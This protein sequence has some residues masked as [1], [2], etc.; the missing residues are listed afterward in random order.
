MELKIE[1]HEIDGKKYLSLTQLCGL[2]DY[3]IDSVKCDLAKF[4]FF[5]TNKSKKGSY[6][7]ELENCLK[8]IDFYMKNKNHNPNKRQIFNK[9][10]DHLEDS[11][12]ENLPSSKAINISE[13]QEVADALIGLFEKFCRKGK[14]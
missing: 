3:R 8:I 11:F 6:F 5:K 12:K 7:L 2:V 1:P 10:I 9:A 14:S 4:K 13:Q